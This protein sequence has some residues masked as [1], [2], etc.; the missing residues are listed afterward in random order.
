MD[1]GATLFGNIKR[2][3]LP[4]VESG[5]FRF[6][7]AAI[8]LQGR[9]WSSPLATI[10][11]RQAEHSPLADRQNAHWVRGRLQHLFGVAGTQ[12]DLET[13]SQVDDRSFNDRLM[14]NA[15]FAAQTVEHGTLICFPFICTESFAETVLIHG[16]VLER[17]ADK[18]HSMLGSMTQAFVD[19][20]L[21]DSSLSN[22]E[23]Y[24]VIF[25]SRFSF[26]IRNG[27]PFS[28]FPGF[29]S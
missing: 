3:L 6:S 13:T 7:P 29:P 17:N 8:E 25:G 21:A 2:L 15:S 20:L 9:T 23:D 10:A 18:Y 24:G 5:R 14:L 27:V 22:Y 16:A 1:V 4:E 28:E 12:G 11:M 26:G 19:L